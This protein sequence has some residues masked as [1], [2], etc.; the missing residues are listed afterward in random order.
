MQISSIS[1]V[2][3][4]VG[5]STE[6]PNYQ[7]VDTLGSLCQWWG[8]SKQDVV[9]D[10]C[11]QFVRLDHHSLQKFLSNSQNSFTPIRV[12]KD[13]VSSHLQPFSSGRSISLVGVLGGILFILILIAFV[14][15]IRH[16]KRYRD[17]DGVGYQLRYV[18]HMRPSHHLL[19]SL[20]QEQVRATPPP[21]YHAVI[22]LKEK[23][24]E[25]PSYSQAVKASGSSGSSVPIGT[26]ESGTCETGD[27]KICGTCNI[28]VCGTL[29]ASGTSRTLCGTG[30]STSSHNETDITSANDCDSVR[31]G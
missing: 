29:H 13:K 4:M 18:H 26:C 11:H 2:V 9:P 10:I 14:T 17:Q 30:M 12:P 7:R 15:C 5:S 31:S 27:S 24:E 23:E 16:R 22:K 6:L 8:D 28:E 25:L 19:A 1:P 21:D 3:D 20:A